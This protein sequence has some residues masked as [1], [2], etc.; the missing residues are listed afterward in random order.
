MSEETP[1]HIGE[2]RKRVRASIADTIVMGNALAEHV[3]Q[4]DAVTTEAG[5]VESTFGYKPGW[6]DA[7]I[8]TAYVP[9]LAAHHVAAVRRDVYPNWE[10]SPADLTVEERLA[11][12]ESDRTAA[13]D[14][15]SRRLANLE[16][17]VDVDV[18]RRLDALDKEADERDVR[19]RALMARNEPG[20]PEQKSYD[21]GPGYHGL[22]RETPAQA[23]E[24]TG[25]E[26]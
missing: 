19:I 6:T 14:E 4:R 12:L 9:H 5:D 25:G 26:G 24:A 13:L 1:S 21:A 17:R 23:S 7:R 3:W 16:E 2:P 15:L 20:T 10:A 18:Y 11:A 22:T 8:A